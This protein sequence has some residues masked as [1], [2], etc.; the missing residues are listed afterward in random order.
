MSEPRDADIANETASGGGGSARSS[1]RAEYGLWS[2][3]KAALQPWNALGLEHQFLIAATLAV[4]LSMA[5]L[6]YWVE[7]R[8]RSSWVQGMAQIGA[9]SVQGYL[10]RHVQMLDTSRVLP[11]E[12]R[13]EI[14]SLLSRT[15]LGT[16]VAIIKIWGLD[17]SLIFSTRASD[18]HSELGARTIERVKAGQVVVHPYYDEVTGSSSYIG[19]Y[20]PLR[21]EVTGEIIAIGEFY[22]YSNFLDQEIKDVKYATWLVIFLAS[23]VIVILLQLMIKRASYLISAQQDLLRA[24]LARAGALAERNNILRRAADRARLNAT[25]LNEAYLASIGAD[26]HDGPIQM[27]SLMMLKLP[28]TGVQAEE[29]G[30]AGRTTASVRAD[31][32]PLIQQTLADLRNLSA[33]LVLPEVENLSAAETV[34]LA[35]TRH[36]HQTGTTVMRDVADMPLNVPRAIRVCAYRIVQEGLTNAYKHAGGHGQRVSARLQAGM[37]EI[38][39]GDSGSAPPPRPLS[40]PAA[41]KLGLRGMK[42]RIKALRGSLVVRRLAGGGT[43]ILASLPVR[44]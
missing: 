41:A 17:G 13:D 23:F 1:D 22:E 19:I 24:N 37:L 40:S 29:P 3:L 26:I 32:E 27:L 18:T 15:S 30:A 11:Q 25:V 28:D 33:G 9:L 2:L 39:V 36:E 34:R 12:S 10:A 7:Q 43:E 31:L 42:N 35:I 16:G 20:A 21:K 6:G 5:S 38:V 44:V 8:V 4:G 14:Q